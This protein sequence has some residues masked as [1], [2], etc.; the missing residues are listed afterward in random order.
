MNNITCMDT[1]CNVHMHHPLREEHSLQ[2]TSNT[3]AQQPALQQP[4]KP[5]DAL[6]SAFPAAP[7][8]LRALRIDNAQAS[9]NNQNMPET[10]TSG[11]L[12]LR[13]SPSCTRYSSSKPR[14]TSCKAYTLAKPP[15]K[16]MT[17]QATSQL[18]HM[19][20]A[21]TASCLHTSMPQASQS[22]HQMSNT[23]TSSISTY[24]GPTL[25]RCCS[26]HPAVTAVTAPHNLHTLPAKH[27][28]CEP[29]VQADEPRSNVPAAPAFCLRATNF[30]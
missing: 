7:A 22:N 26:I 3:P 13:Y 19:S 23:D 17:C 9:P 11:I 27:T 24:K 20:P 12:N 15:G 21:D 18:E 8:N 25:P 10:D 4:G 16:P 14:C 1:Q 6:P 29:A 2:T 28:R 30:P 5:G